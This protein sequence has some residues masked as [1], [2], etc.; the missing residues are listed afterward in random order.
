MARLASLFHG[1]GEFLTLPEPGI[2]TAW[3]QNPDTYLGLARSD[4]EILQAPP[5]PKHHHHLRKRHDLASSMY[6]M[7]Y[8]L[9]PYPRYAMVMPFIINDQ[10][11]DSWLL[12][13]RVSLQRSPSAQSCLE[14]ARYANRALSLMAV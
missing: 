10:P 13:T 14:A 6:L 12:T 9:L 2:D 7:Y 3:P 1:V 8:G 5:L 11:Q 4:S